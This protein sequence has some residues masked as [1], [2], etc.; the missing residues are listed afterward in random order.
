[1][2]VP[3]LLDA[4][5]VTG[6]T[7]TQKLVLLALCNTHNEKTGRNYP[8]MS[9]IAEMCCLK[10]NAVLK[11]ISELEKLG[12]LQKNKGDHASNSYKIEL[13]ACILK[14]Q[15]V[16]PKDTG[17]VSNKY[18]GCIP[19]IHKHGINME[20]N[21]NLTDDDADED[22]QRPAN[23]S[24]DGLDVQSR[25]QCQN[26]PRPPEEKF[27]PFQSPE[28]LPVVKAD[29]KAVVALQLAYK[30]RMGNVPDAHNPDLLAL[31]EAGVT[32]D[33]LQAAIDTAQAKG[34]SVAN[35]LK[36]C[37]GI[38]RANRKNALNAAG[39][40]QNIKHMPMYTPDQENAAKAVLERFGAIC[41]S[42]APLEIIDQD[43]IAKVLKAMD[44]VKANRTIKDDDD[45]Q[46]WF[47]HY[48]IKVEKTKSFM[49]K[50]LNLIL[51]PTVMTQI[52]EEK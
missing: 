13:S 25:M 49:G 10:R 45:L 5:S 40:F 50:S 39:S 28:P 6:I 27:S 8:S 21:R 4:W 46:D 38:I 7:S 2:S 15:G 24:V 47:K 12:I 20:V 41:K 48:F 44:W 42:L 34:K 16:Y 11:A 26:S 32:G 37:L 1:M 35:M 29:R 43:R 19:K 31:V 3:L 23:D 51:S 18:M 17:G 52:I 33:E 9:S 36:Y 22:G 14:I 30:A